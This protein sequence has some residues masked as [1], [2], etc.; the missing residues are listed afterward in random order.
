MVSFA[1]NDVEVASPFTS[2]RDHLRALADD[3]LAEGTTALYDAVTWLPEV[4]LSSSRPKR[5]AIVLTDGFDNS[6]VIDPEDSRQ[7]VLATQLPVYVVDLSRFGH[8][9][10]VPDREDAVSAPLRELARGT[11]GR[12]YRTKKSHPADAC[13]Q[14]NGK[15]AA[16]AI[17]AR[18]RGRLIES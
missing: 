12:Y 1:G 16:T 18:V 3:W 2:S 14:R 13:C 17:C 6:S 11:G 5:A 8:P 15:R 10:S 4:S 9:T 7:R